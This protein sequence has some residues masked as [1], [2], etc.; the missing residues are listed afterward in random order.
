MKAYSS[1]TR[2]ASLGEVVDPVSETVPDQSLSVREIMARY[3]NGVRDDLYNDGGEYTEDMEDVS[4]L[5]DFERLDLLRS[6]RDSV[7]ERSVA[8]VAVAPSGEGVIEPVK[9]VESVDDGK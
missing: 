4:A 3:V 7:P 1:F 8:P 2:K 9:P 6:L 5:D